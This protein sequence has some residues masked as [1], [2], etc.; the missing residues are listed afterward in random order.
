MREIKFRI[1]EK[2]FGICRS[3][4]LINAIQQENLY[5]LN[6]PPSSLAKNAFY[7]ISLKV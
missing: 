7:E 3:I 1:R 2:L 4:N 5:S 6:C